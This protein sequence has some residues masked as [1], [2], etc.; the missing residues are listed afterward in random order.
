MQ[1]LYH[2]SIIQNVASLNAHAIKLIWMYLCKLGAPV[3]G[4][5][6]MKILYDRCLMNGKKPGGKNTSLIFWYHTAKANA[7]IPWGL[8]D[9]SKWIFEDIN[10]RDDFPLYLQALAY[11]RME[12]SESGEGLDPLTKIH[13][14]KCIMNTNGK[15]TFKKS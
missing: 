4:L 14:E 13:V 2:Y 6:F 7:G 8:V 5:I 15:L 10:Q 9:Y 12:L 3:T 11:N 1:D